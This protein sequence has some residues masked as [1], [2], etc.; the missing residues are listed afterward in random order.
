M[1]DPI[2]AGTIRILS[3]ESYDADF[4]VRNGVNLL[5]Y[6]FVVSNSNGAD[7]VHNKMITLPGSNFSFE[8]DESTQITDIVDTVGLIQDTENLYT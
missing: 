1:H 8:I 6:W 7:L 4:Y 2:K 5:K 3:P